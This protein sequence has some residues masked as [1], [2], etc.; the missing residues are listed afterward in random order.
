MRSTVALRNRHRPYRRLIRHPSLR[1][2]DPLWFAV[3]VPEVF[4]S[5][6]TC[7]RRTHRSDCARPPN[8]WAAVDT[9]SGRTGGP[10]TERGRSGPWL[11]RFC[12]W[13]GWLANRPSGRPCWG[14]GCYKWPRTLYP[15][16]PVV[17]A[18]WINGGS[19]YV[20]PVAGS[21]D[22]ESVD[23]VE[24]CV[25]TLLLA[26]YRHI[27]TGKS[28][29]NAALTMTLVLI[30]PSKWLWLPPIQEVFDIRNNFHWFFLVSKMQLFHYNSK[31][32]VCS[33]VHLSV[34]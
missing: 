13:A 25:Y 7:H 2:P 20:C 26:G 30:T 24:L 6:H 17:N 18:G 3:V 16:H 5:R 10:V 22:T 11:A 12:D 33:W 32:H 4:L 19:T 14:L 29:M 31:Y 21:R 8:M 27:T 9:S 23:S 15:W 1:R 28:H 34:T